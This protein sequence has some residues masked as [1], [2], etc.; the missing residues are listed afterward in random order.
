MVSDSDE[1]TPL[2]GVAE[3]EVLRIASC[4]DGRTHRR[5]STPL[6]YIFSKD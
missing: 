2:G 4:S 3:A 1:R 5:I 6:T